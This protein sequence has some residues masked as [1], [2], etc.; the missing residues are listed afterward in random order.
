LKKPAGGA[1]FSNLIPQSHMR[2]LSLLG[3]RT[4]PR[5][6]GPGG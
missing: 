1:L 3:T 2:L 4:N 5:K 6:T